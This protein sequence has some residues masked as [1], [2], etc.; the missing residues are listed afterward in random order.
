MRTGADMHTHSQT[1]MHARAQYRYTD[2]LALGPGLCPYVP[3]PLPHPPCA[4]VIVIIPLLSL[5]VLLVLRCR[6]IT[7]KTAA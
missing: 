3:H 7:L 2:T 5:I 4:H 6:R 1:N